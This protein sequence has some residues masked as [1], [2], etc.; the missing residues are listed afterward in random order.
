M[1][2]KEKVLWDV[3]DQTI[4]KTT[5]PDIIRQKVK[6]S[7]AAWLKERNSFGGSLKQIIRGRRLTSQECALACG[8]PRTT[9]QSWE[10]GRTAPNVTEFQDLCKHLE[11]KSF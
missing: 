10:A 11:F 9:W 6:T 5:D 7:G 2:N 1:N 8:I 4:F 3:V